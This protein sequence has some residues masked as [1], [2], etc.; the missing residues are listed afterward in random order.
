MRAVLEVLLHEVAPCPFLDPAAPLDT[1]AT[2]P[3]S[4]LEL[5]QILYLQRH[6]SLYVPPGALLRLLRWFLGKQDAPRPAPA[7]VSVTATATPVHAPAPPPAPATSLALTMESIAPG[8]AD[9]DD[10]SASL[11]CPVAGWQWLVSVTDRGRAADMLRAQRQCAFAALSAAAPPAPPPPPM[12]FTLG[13]LKAP[14]AGATKAEPGQAAAPGAEGTQ[15]EF[16]A[17]A[18][19]RN[20]RNCLHEPPLFALQDP[21]LTNL[22]CTPHPMQPFLPSD[23]SLAPSAAGKPAN[24][25]PTPLPYVR[26]HT[27]PRNRAAFGALHPAFPRLKRGPRP[28]RLTEAEAR[29]TGLLET[30]SVQGRTPIDQGW[31]AE[32]REVSRELWARVA[33]AAKDQEQ[34]L[35]PQ[36]GEGAAPPSGSNQPA[37]EQQQGVMTGGSADSPANAA[38]ATVAASHAPSLSLPPPPPA[39]PTPSPASAF[40]SLFPPAAKPGTAATLTPGDSHPTSPT[41][42]PDPALNPVTAVLRRVFPEAADLARPRPA[43]GPTSS[44]SSALGSSM[45]LGLGQTSLSLC[46]VAAAPPGLPAPLWPMEMPKRARRGGNPPNL[47][48][49]YR[50]LVHD[51]HGPPVNPRHQQEGVRDGGMSASGA[52]PPSDVPHRSPSETY[53]FPVSH[54]FLLNPHS[55]A[56]TQTGPAPGWATHLGQ[57]WALFGQALRKSQGLTSSPSELLQ[58]PAPDALGGQ[59]ADLPPGLVDSLEA[60]LGSLVAGTATT[61][62]TTTTFAPGLDSVL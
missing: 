23:P 36:Q 22:S 43:L 56:T 42:A 39:P 28:K 5:H 10:G 38:A 61:T 33:Q 49:R 34:Q 13:P 27:H 30:P 18:E 52:V 60:A 57:Q 54:P 21:L 62:T 44:F 59:Y 16:G 31:S 26:L 50:Q 9:F 40:S 45:G 47:V 41:G 48:H 19:E 35:Q 17:E 4:V 6:D 55:H 14:K 32:R 37:P 1:C 53:I 3:L 46:T 51:M 12:S 58:P 20:D 15:T 11:G 8:P 7:S 2:I 29:A 24:S 25:K